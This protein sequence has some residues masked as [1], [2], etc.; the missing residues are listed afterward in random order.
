MASHDQE[1]VGCEELSL[2]HPDPVVLELN[3]LENLLRGLSLLLLLLL[4]HTHFFCV[5]PAYTDGYSV[6]DRIIEFDVKLF[7]VCFTSVN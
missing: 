5:C 1:H 4:S 3:R 6:F 2:A 7:W